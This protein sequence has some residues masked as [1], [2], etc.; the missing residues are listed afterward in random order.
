MSDTKRRKIDD[1]SVLDIL[2]F[3]EGYKFARGRDDLEALLAP[4]DT[5][6]VNSRGQ[7][8]KFVPKDTLSRLALHE[9]VQLIW[10]SINVG[11]SVHISGQAGSGK[12]EVLMQ[13][14][15]GCHAQEGKQKFTYALCG[16]TG[17][18]A[19]NVGG[20]TLHSQLSLGLCTG[21][22][23]SIWE[24]ID[25]NRQSYSKTLDF[26]VNTD[27]LIIDE[28]SM[29]AP[30][31]FGKLDYLARKSREA[32]HLPFGGMLLLVIG[33]FLQLDPIGPQN[34]FLS[35]AKYVFQTESWKAIRWSRLWLKRNYRQEEGSSF[36]KLLSMIR[37]GRCDDLHKR[38]L[39]S[40]LNKNIARSVHQ[41]PVADPCPFSRLQPLH[42]F[43]HLKKVDAYNTRKL[44]ECGKQSKLV[45][46][47]PFLHVEPF[48][49][50]NPLI[51]KQDQTTADS[52]L[53]NPKAG[54]LFP[55][56]SLQLCVGAQVMMRCNSLIGF[57][58]ANGSMGVVTA[59]YDDRVSVRF[60]IG[61][62]MS[63]QAIDV[64]RFQF[65]H[66]V[67]KTAFLV[68]DQFPLI[69]A[70]ATTIHKVQGLTLDSVHV[71]LGAC[72]AYGQVYVALSRVRSIDDL[73]IDNFSLKGI[74]AH[75]SA[76]A[77]EDIPPEDADEDLAD[78]FC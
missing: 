21:S 61:G 69:L 7:P 45:N 5:W 35:N 23:K 57:R 47:A 49:K 64:R 18:A 48:S 65:K 78:V 34:D 12:S 4:A 2:V 75:R 62:V 44:E 74:K 68:L 14:L 41:I 13:F 54:D 72:F 50:L 43:S 67:G 52:L 33:D 66:K 76:V 38:I 46:Y 31:F 11:R 20:T 55:I 19:V 16:S 40:R 22:A 70:W 36:A 10:R 56:G 73:F 3:K 60:M 77:F 27:L 17:I 51:C 59:L 71:Y 8:S 30:E 26:L 37:L 28:I 58:I 1:P 42:L 53:E 9:D 15:R 39:E 6:H 29:V 63:D 32:T 25:G 24:R